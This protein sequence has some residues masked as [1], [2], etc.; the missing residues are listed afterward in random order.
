M[1]LLS[2]S[3]QFPANSM[4]NDEQNLSPYAFLRLCVHA[5][6]MGLDRT[7]S[8]GRAW[9]RYRKSRHVQYQVKWRFA[10]YFHAKGGKWNRK[11]ANWLNDRITE[12]YN[13]EIALGAVIGPGLRIGH[14]NGIVIS[15]VVRAGANLVIRQNTTIGV[16]DHTDGRIDIGD[17]V[18]IG[19]HS[20]IIANN[21]KIGSNVTIGAQT[22]INKDLPDGVTC[23]T[24]R[25]YVII[26]QQ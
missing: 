18:S 12:R 11:F 3:G 23:Y 22:F 26:H 5:E 25:E 17:N 4:I 2:K 9:R 6:T 21:L 7:F 13:V 8:W 24:K 15:N 1:R 19:A 10:S 20:C 16:K 14:H